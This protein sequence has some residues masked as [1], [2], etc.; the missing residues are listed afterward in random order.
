[1][2]LEQIGFLLKR[3]ESAGWGD[4]F[5]AEIINAI[6]DDGC[7]IITASNGFADLFRPFGPLTD[8]HRPV[9][10]RFGRPDFTQANATGIWLLYNPSCCRGQIERVETCFM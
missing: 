2:L 9:S 10:A 6:G 3:G 7:G 1:M 4:I 8:G 5:F